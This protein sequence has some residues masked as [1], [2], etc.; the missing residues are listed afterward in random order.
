[1]LGTG[2]VVVLFSLFHVLDIARRRGETFEYAGAMFYGE[3]GM[4]FVVGE[5]FEMGEYAIFVTLA[6]GVNL[7]VTFVV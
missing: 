4:M 1:M 2:I 6:F 5:A 7:L 3:L